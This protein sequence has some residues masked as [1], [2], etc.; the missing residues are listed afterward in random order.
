MNLSQRRV[1]LGHDIISYGPKYNELEKF[2]IDVD[3]LE[4][5]KALIKRA[6][7]RSKKRQKF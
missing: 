6:I 7:K 1:K 2:K 3:F 5:F 4:Y